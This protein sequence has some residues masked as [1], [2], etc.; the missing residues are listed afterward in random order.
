MII[1]CFITNQ[2]TGVE[3][4]VSDYEAHLNEQVKEGKLNQQMANYLL[5]KESGLSFNTMIYEQ[6]EEYDWY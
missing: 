3:F 1:S 2:D 6:L 4:S 5:G